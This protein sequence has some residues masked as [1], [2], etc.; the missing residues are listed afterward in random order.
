MKKI[1][2]GSSNISKISFY[3]SILS[4][5][6]FQ[7]V[8]PNDFK[9]TLK[10]EEDIFDI[11]GN[12]IKKS[13][14]FAN[15]FNLP[16]ISDDTGVFI[17]A[18]NNEPGVA[19]RRW[20][21]ELPNEISDLEWL[22]YFIKKIEKLDNNELFCYKHQIISIALPNGD[23]LETEFKRYG[24]ISK[25]K[26]TF[27]FVQ[28]APFS[29]HFYLDEYKKIES[30]LTAKELNSYS[31]KLSKEVKKMMYILLKLKNV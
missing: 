4:N 6:D 2:I 24:K 31:A 29:A 8:T 14:A 23:H 28:G 11:R 13:L 25:K 3:S 12:A 15:K 10:I 1:L 5:L 9:S 18:L 7:V 19:V 30:D 20:A 26:R 21:G 27:G 22:D 17:P 16:S